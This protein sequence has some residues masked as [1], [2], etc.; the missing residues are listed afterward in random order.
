[1]ILQLFEF[2]QYIVKEAAQNAYTWLWNVLKQLTSRKAKKCQEFVLKATGALNY[3]SLEL[4]K[5][6]TLSST[7]K[8]VD[9]FSV[10]QLN[11]VKLDISALMAFDV[12][13]EVKWMLMDAGG[14]T[15]IRCAYDHYPL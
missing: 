6:F 3:I 9:T 15:A 2:S 13:G 10:K 1:M 7:S 12:P 8:D 5:S 4:G 14:N 11:G